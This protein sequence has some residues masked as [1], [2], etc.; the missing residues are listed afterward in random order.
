MDY[1]DDAYMD[2]LEKEFPFLKDEPKM[3]GKAP[4]DVQRA[5]D[6]EMPSDDEEEMMAEVCKG[7]GEKLKE[8]YFECLISS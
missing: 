2:D 4:A 5:M 7:K 8:M 1:E 3:G 6:D